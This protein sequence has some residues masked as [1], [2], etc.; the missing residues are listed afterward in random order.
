MITDKIAAADRRF[1]SRLER[2][3]LEAIA[4]VIGGVNQPVECRA[5][6]EA[7]S[8]AAADCRFGL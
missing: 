5:N 6:L 7:W 4:F 3:G 1:L 8:R 2:A